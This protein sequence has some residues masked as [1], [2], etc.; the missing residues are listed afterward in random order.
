VPEQLEAD[1]VLNTDEAQ[2]AVTG[3]GGDMDDAFTQSADTLSSALNDAITGVPEV[4]ITANTDELAPAITSALGD[5]DTALP[6]TANVDEIDPSITGALDAVDTALPMTANTDEID[7]AINDALGAVD[8]SV[9][10]NAETGALAPEID[11]AI[12][13]V[14]TP[15]VTVNLAV[16]DRQFQTEIQSAIDTI[17]EATIPVTAD[18]SAA[19]DAFSNLADSATQASGAATAASNI[20]SGAMQGLGEGAVT[21][22][23]GFDKV[24]AGSIA[25]SGAASLATGRF[26]EFASSLTEV[27]GATGLL[28]SGAVAGAT[29]IGIFSE[30]G[31][32]A[33]GA[34]QMFSNSLGDMASRLKS[35]SDIPGLNTDLEKMR[36]E[37]GGDSSALE[38]TTARLYSTATGA[39]VA[40][41]KAVTF[42]E[43]LVAMSGYAVSLNP[44]LGDIANVTQSLS[45]AFARGGKFAQSYGF[46]L[47]QQEIVARAR[48]DTGK[49][50]TSQ[51]TYEDKAMAGAEIVT[52]RYCSR[53]RRPSPSWASHWRRRSWTR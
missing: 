25:A 52:E 41:D 26:G 21:A 29:A 18:T 15:E 49:Q 1:L 14:P 10:V 34:A 22:A 44:N 45:T 47:T 43:Q 36:S 2:R 32:H 46:E 3:L 11:D 31:I 7:P 19:E 35:L 50:L 40:K 6:M 16:D 51:L 37:L 17:P 23:E 42:V 48:T 12:Q 38:E 39:G 24:R 9:M 33:Q 30:A 20:A 27:E 28:A 53:S 13:A 8:A 5:V 4:P